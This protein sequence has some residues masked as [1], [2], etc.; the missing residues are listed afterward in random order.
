[1]AQAEIKKKI[2]MARFK[3]FEKNLSHNLGK[4]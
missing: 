3:M 4:P 1:M 2:L